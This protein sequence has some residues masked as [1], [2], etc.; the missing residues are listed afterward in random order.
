MWISRP[1]P[2]FDLRKGNIFLT[3]AFWRTAGE[4]SE[5]PEMSL[6][7]KWVGSLCLKSYVLKLGMG[8]VLKKKH[9]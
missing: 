1:I 6:K 5:N 9:V 3:K 4:F 2:S 7:M 8:G